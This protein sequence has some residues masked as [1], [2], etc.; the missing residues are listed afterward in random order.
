M[1]KSIIRSGHHRLKLTQKKKKKFG[2]VYREFNL[3][4]GLSLLEFNLPGLGYLGWV[5]FFVL[6]K[7]IIDFLQG[8]IPGIKRF[9]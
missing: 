1:I 5:K 3:W 4:V 7:G 6:V 9:F 2:L 8:N